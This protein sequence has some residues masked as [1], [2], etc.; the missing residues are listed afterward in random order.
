MALFPQFTRP[1]YFIQ[2]IIYFGL[3]KMTC[4]AI[5]MISYGVMGRRMFNYM[6]ESTW[7][8]TISRV[9]GGGIIIAAI[10]IARG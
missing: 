10:A 1:E 4:L 2:D 5:V 7:A 9:F 3:L 8:N 6:G